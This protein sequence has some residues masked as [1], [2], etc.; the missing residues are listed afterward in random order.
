M[1][2][3]EL[4]RRTRMHTEC[5]PPDLVTY[6]L[7]HGHADVVR[8]LA[9]DGEW[10]C[11]RAWAQHLAEQGRREEAWG[12]LAPYV[13]TGW[14]TAAGRA[15]ELLD[16][17][18]RGEEAIALVRPYADAGERSALRDL[19]L[20]LARHGRA[21]EAYGLL[22]PHVGTGSSPSPWWR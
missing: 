9:R 13:E 10:F 16:A 2:A 4:D 21:E 17:W 12:V 18:G 19:A 22:R 11:A 5:V 3:A 15:A 6:L 7:G 1:D 20:L 8:D 14:W